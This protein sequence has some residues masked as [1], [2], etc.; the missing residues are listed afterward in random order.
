MKNK[1]GHPKHGDKSRYIHIR[2]KSPTLFAK[3]KFRT[4][5]IGDGLK[6][7]YG[8]EKSKKKW[9]AQNMM[10]PKNKVVQHGAG[11]SIRSVKLKSRLKEHGIMM[12]KIKQMKTGGSADYTIR[13]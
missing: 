6:Q 11:I 12:N 7:V 5:D 8:N 1:S 9:T 4:I 13:R 3:G 10:I 2:L